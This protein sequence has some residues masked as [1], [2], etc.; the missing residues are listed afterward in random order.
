MTAAQRN[1]S[2]PAPRG[3][4]VRTGAERLVQGEFAELDGQ[5]VGVLSN[6]TAVLPDLTHLVDSMAA[7]S[8]VDITAAFGPEHGFRG[9]SQAESD[10]T[11]FVDD[12][13]GLPVYNLYREPYQDQARI[14]AAAGIDTLVFDIQDVGVRFYTYVWSMYEA[15]LAAALEGKRFVVLDRPNPIGGVQVGGPMMHLDE[16][17]DERAFFRQVPLQ[18]GMTVGELA[19]Y[20][21]DVLLPEQIGASVDDLTVMQMSGWRRAMSF[22]DTALTTWVLPSPNLPTVETAYV[23]PGT[24]LFEGT[25]L[26]AGRGTTRPFELIGAPF[27]DDEWA[28]TLN[29]LGLDGVTFR[30]AFFEPTFSVFAGEVCQGVQVHVTSRTEFDP[31]RAAVGMLVT[32]HAHYPDFEMDELLDRH[33]GT[34]RLR[35][36]ILDGAGVEEVVAGWEDELAQFERLRAEYLLYS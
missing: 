2:D 30:H 29:A 14:I 15:M 36:A 34:A 25:N 3:A 17:E 31:I 10:E 19:R 27:L 8:Q 35:T 26:S 4:S 11:S 5:R 16:V 9:A 1:D 20:F 28:G 18:H 33:S 22:D 24:G 6:H 7:S 13:T 21:N 12:K 32:A 23:Y